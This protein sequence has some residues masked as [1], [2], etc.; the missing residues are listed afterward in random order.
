MHAEPSHPSTTAL[1]AA[2]QNPSYPAQLEEISSQLLALRPIEL[3]DLTLHLL[4]LDIR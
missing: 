1:Y 4:G 3:I 2:M